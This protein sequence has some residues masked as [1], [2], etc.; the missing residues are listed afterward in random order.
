MTLDCSNTNRDGPGRFR[1]EADNP[2]FQACY[3]NSANDE[4]VYNEFVSERINSPANAENFQFKT[5]EL[6]S[7]MN[8]SLTFDAS[9]ELPNLQRNGTGTNRRKK[10]IFGSG[11]GSSIFGGSKREKESRR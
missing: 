11:A 6:K 1:T 5:V 4:Q 3:F 7:K 10:T 2:E 8:S 9:E